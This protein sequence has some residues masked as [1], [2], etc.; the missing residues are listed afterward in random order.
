MAQEATTRAKPSLLYAGI[1]IGSADP[2]ESPGELPYVLQR[3]F[4]G[5]QYRILEW[6]CLQALSDRYFDLLRGLADSDYA[7]DHLRWSFYRKCLL[8]AMPL[9]R[10]RIDVPELL[11]ATLPEL[12]GDSDVAADLRAY[13]SQLNR[14]LLEFGRRQASRDRD[15]RRATRAWRAGEM[16]VE[17]CV[18]ER[19]AIWLLAA[20]TIHANADLISAIRARL[21]DADDA[22]LAEAWGAALFPY[23]WR[24]GLGDAAIDAA[25]SDADDAREVNRL[26]SMQRQ[27]KQSRLKWSRMLEAPQLAVES[28]R[29]RRLLG[30]Q[31][32]GGTVPL[33]ELERAQSAFDEMAQQARA[34]LASQQTE[35][36]RAVK[37]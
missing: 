12:R 7:V 21:T 37:R 3:P 34:E 16:T 30:M 11:D 2:S 4:Y 25:L 32:I 13:E 23:L 22:R 10:A 9:A 18:D 26:Q 19:D 8:P 27:I 5:E 29:H 35:A 28:V 1:V 17:T 14:R 24:R 33:D 31:Q 6:Q 15:V 20:E 36:A